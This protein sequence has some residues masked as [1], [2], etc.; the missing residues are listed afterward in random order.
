M[1]NTNVTFTPSR[2]KVFV[3]NLESGL[4]QTAGGIILLD[5]N[6]KQEGIRDRWA[7]VYKVGSDVTDIKPG[8][9][10]LIKQGR[11]SNKIKMHDEGQEVAVWFIEYPTSVLL[12]S[13]SD[14]NTRENITL[15]AF[16]GYHSGD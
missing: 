6:M 11:W 15:P 16:D 9:W 8:E 2:E 4:A 14:P 12:V 7:R 1:E 10:V 3:T 5:D 13:D